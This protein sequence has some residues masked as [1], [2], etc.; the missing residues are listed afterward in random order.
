MRENLEFEIEIKVSSFRLSYFISKDW[1][2]ID[3][4]RRTSNDEKW[5]RDQ[6]GDFFF[7]FI[8]EIYFKL[9]VFTLVK[10]WKKTKVLRERN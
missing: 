3:C 9:Q 6:Q 1:C 2:L 8:F 4:R 7:C 10:I 5:F